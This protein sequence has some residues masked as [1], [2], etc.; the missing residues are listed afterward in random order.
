MC[1]KLRFKSMAGLALTTFAFIIF[2]C[3]PLFSEDKFDATI[4]S[5]QQHE[6]PQWFHDAKFGIFIHW[7]L[8]SVPGWAPTTGEPGSVEWNVWF[9]NNPYAEWYLNTMKIP[10]SPTQ[11]YHKKIY[12]DDFDYYD[13]IPI[14]NQEVA[15]WKPDEWAKLFKKV[16][17]RYVVLTTKHHDGFTLWPSKV[18]NS[19]FKLEQQACQ[20]D[21]VGELTRAVREQDLKMGLYYSGGLDWSF[22]K[23]P[24]QEMKVLPDHIPQDQAYA[25]YVDAHWREL[26]DKYQP[27]ILWNDIGY[28]QKSDLIKILA[29]YYNRFP[30]GL[31]NNRWSLSFSDFTTPEY[32]Q[33]DKIIQKKWESCRGLG[34][35]FGYNRNEGDEHM[36]TANKLVDLLVDIVSKNGNLLLNIGPKADGTIP[37][38]QEKRLRDLGG[39]L[40][41]NGEAIFGTRPWLQANGTTDEK[42]D[43]RFTKKDDILYAILLDKPAQNKIT[44]NQIYAE[45][46]SIIKLLGQEEPL[47][48]TQQ[49]KN[50]VIN[51]PENIPGKYA[52]TIK[53][54]PRAWR[55]DQ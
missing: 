42:V 15:Q 25:D 10:G 31:V 28:P 55:L 34:F 41:I 26:I 27:S 50:L 21:L 16:G 4:E 51:L 53:I 9:K 48:W 11:K 6:V 29:D 8:Y 24:I 30:E 20:R 19:N 13:F 36:L 49:G 17:A 3:K 18:R 47:Q 44:L 35:S 40:D 22:D 23:T 46:N 2:F 14:F 7:G 32:S 39:W 33:Y 12:G 52:Y 1:E 5:I 38:A 43:V 54:S 37:P 45:K